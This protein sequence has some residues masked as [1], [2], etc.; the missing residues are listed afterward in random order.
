MMS[1]YKEALK[2]K[3]IAAKILLPLIE[4]EFSLIGDEHPSL[5]Q[6]TENME[7]FTEIFR[8]CKAHKWLTTKQ[9]T[10]KGKYLFLL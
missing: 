9:I 3:E 10:R 2:D 7:Q 6:S 4:F 5:I 8:I 1:V